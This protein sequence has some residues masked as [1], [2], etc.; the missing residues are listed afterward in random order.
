MRDIA[1]LIT[2]DFNGAIS[3]IVN[4][5]IIFQK[6]FCYSLLAGKILPVSIVNNMLFKHAASED[7]TCGL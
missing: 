7:G 5:N 2:E 1:E 3:V 6:A 4:N